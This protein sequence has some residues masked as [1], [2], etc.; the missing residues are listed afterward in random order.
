L[1]AVKADGPVGDSQPSTLNNEALVSRIHAL[2]TSFAGEDG[3]LQSDEFRGLAASV[4]A[5]LGMDPC[6]F[7]DLGSLFDRFDI[8]GDGHLDENECVMLAESMLRY[9]MYSLKPKVAGEVS[10]LSVGCKKVSDFYALGKKVGQGAQG[11]VYMAAE[12][13][14]GQPRVIKMFDK[15]N[16]NAPPDEIREEFWLLRSLDHPR[17]QRIYDVF[18]DRSNLYMVAEPYYGG[19]LSDIIENAYSAGANVTSTYLAKV[20]N[21]VLQGVTYLHNKYI[22]H[23]DL[24]E[25]N[26]MITTD[27]GYA[28]PSIVVIDFGLARNFA[29]RAGSGGT[30]GYMPPEVWKEGPWTPKGDIFS[31]GVLIYQLFSCGKKC[32]TG[33]DNSTHE[34]AA[35]HGEPDYSAITSAWK[36]CTDLVQ[37]LKAMLQKDPN[38]RPSACKCAEHE[39]FVTRVKPDP[40][41]WYQEDTI[42]DD[43]IPTLE[44]LSAKSRLQQAILTDIAAERNLCELHDLNATFNALDADHNGVITRDEMR[45]AL[46]WKMDP[47]SLEKA[48]DCLVGPSGQVPYTTFMAQLLSA[49]AADEN[50]LLWTEFQ[51]LDQTSSGYLDSDQIACLLKRPALSSFLACRGVSELMELMDADGDGRIVFEEFRRALAGESK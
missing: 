28:D 27:E 17:I 37:L 8:N 3:K 45:A 33:W 34:E 30:P 51:R 11:V 15:R 13:S 35:T 9:Y 18:E 20:L 38:Q 31:L 16:A 2:F 44:K 4:A 14:T 24:K 40:D 46:D 39:F 7:E 1:A 6:R 29:S 23:C 25:S 49:K 43:I 50:R 5:E 10:M 22:I 32:F 48:I 47:E 26:V 41:D 12:I 42:P 36:R 21:Q 19:T